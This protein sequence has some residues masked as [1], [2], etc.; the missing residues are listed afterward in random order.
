M[1]ISDAYL[2]YVLGNDATMR[3]EFIKEMPKPA[4]RLSLDFS[5]LLGATFF[6]WVISFLLPVIIFILKSN[7]LINSGITILLKLNLE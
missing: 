5:S 1:Q 4:T 2:R 7:F 6:N 3:L